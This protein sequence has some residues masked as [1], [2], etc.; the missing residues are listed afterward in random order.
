[1]DSNFLLSFVGKK[2]LVVVQVL[3]L[4]L[5]FP[6][7][8]IISYYPI[9][10]NNQINQYLFSFSPVPWKLYGPGTLENHINYSRQWT[11]NLTTTMCI[12]VL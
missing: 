8:P 5:P 10:T 7:D 2:L 4:N 9:E 3:M 1:M 6:L 11:T 12:Y